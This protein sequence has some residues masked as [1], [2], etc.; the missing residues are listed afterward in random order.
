MQRSFRKVLNL[1]MIQM[2]VFMAFSC[3]DEPEYSTDP[4]DKLTYS[5]DTL[6]FDT[7]FTTKGSTFRRLRIYNLNE[8]AIK[9][10]RLAIAG[11]ENSPYQIYLSGLEGSTFENVTVNAMDSLLLLAEVTI[12]PANEQLPFLVKDSIT[13]SYNSRMDHVK[14][15]SWGQQA[16]FLKDT[17]LSGQINWAKG[18]PYV[19]QGT[20][21]VDTLSELNISPGTRIYGDNDALLAIRG[22]V[23]A[24]GDTAE[25]RIRFTS[26]REDEPFDNS[27][28]QWF[29]I[30]ILEGSDQNLFEFTDVRNAQFGFRLQTRDE[31]SIADLTLSSVAIEN[32]AQYGILAFNADIEMVNSTISYCALGS[33]AGL[34]GGNYSIIHSALVYYNAVNG[35]QL[36]RNDGQTVLQFSDNIVINDQPVFSPLN[37]QIV[38]S[39]IWSDTNTEEEISLANGGL[40]PFSLLI[41]SSILK[42]SNTDLGINGNILNQDPRFADRFIYDFRLDTLSPAIDN[43]LALG[44]ETDFRRFN[45]DLNTPDIGAFERVKRN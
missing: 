10:D 21:L 14:A 40:A 29:G 1:F 5:T 6:Q 2:V 36:F 32:M 33:F 34:S 26:I 42:T 24:V 38:N 44:I 43:G 45:R 17:V 18:L 30:V 13:L 37:V 12:D 35:I 22:K 41:S 11:G 3:L 25:N 27:P 28:G 7:L 16:N 19:L 23:N 39:I 15:I 4:Q 8:Q 9:I 20:V 31:D